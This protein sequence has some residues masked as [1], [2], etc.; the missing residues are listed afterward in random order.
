MSK[1]QTKIAKKGI[2]LLNLFPLIPPI[3]FDDDLNSFF[4]SVFHLICGNYVA[5]ASASLSPIFVTPLF[6]LLP[7]SLPFKVLR[8]RHCLQRSVHHAFV[9]KQ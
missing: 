3:E 4:W 8:C 6:H 9:K 1:K 7:L 2:S 5:S